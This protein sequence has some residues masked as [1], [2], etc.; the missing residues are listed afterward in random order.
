MEI[1]GINKFILSRWVKLIKDSI[2]PKLKKNE[3]CRNIQKKELHSPIASSVCFSPGTM[4]LRLEK[5]ALVLSF[6]GTRNRISCSHSSLSICDL[7]RPFEQ[8]L[9]SPLSK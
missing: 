2:N 8:A 1:K 3:P 6:R 5:K 4:S 7:L 9:G